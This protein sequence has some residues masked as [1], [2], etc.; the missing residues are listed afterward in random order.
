MAHP[1][2]GRLLRCSLLRRDGSL[3]ASAI[4][5]RLGNVL[6]IQ[7]FRPGGTLS[8]SVDPAYPATA[9]TQGAKVSCDSNAEKSIGSSYWKQPIKWWLGQTPSYLNRDK[10]VNALEAA[11]AEWTNNV[12]YCKYG[13][14]ANGSAPY[15]GK[16]T[17]QYG[18]YDGSNTVD[19]GSIN[20]QGCEGAVAC[21][22]NWYDAN[23]KPVEADTRFSTA[24]HWS[25]NPGAQDFDVQSVAAHE[26]GHVR[27]FDHVTNA[28]HADYTDLMW[29]Y[30][31]PGTTNGR[32][33]GRGDSLEDNQHY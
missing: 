4:R 8:L 26:F 18:T 32:K 23:G 17:R 28:D 29:P 3:F 10:I 20:S 24:F 16:T 19:W 6:A 1:L 31:S 14:Q 5:D 9:S 30:T 22:M 13:D 15:Q 12:N 33:L 21:T 25:L 2:A 11:Q 27:Q 7:F